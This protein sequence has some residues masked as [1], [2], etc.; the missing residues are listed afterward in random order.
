MT[1]LRGGRVNLRKF[2]HG[3]SQGCSPTASPT[4]FVIVLVLPQHFRLGDPHFHQRST[5]LKLCLTTLVY[6]GAAELAVTG[7]RSTTRDTLATRKAVAGLLMKHENMLAKVANSDEEKRILHIR[8]N[9]ANVVS[10]TLRSEDEIDNGKVEFGN[11]AS[12]LHPRL[13]PDSVTRLIF[14]KKYR[15]QTRGGRRA[16]AMGLMLRY[17][18]LRLLLNLNKTTTLIRSACQMAGAGHRL[19]HAP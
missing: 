14:Q 18:R 6:G 10:L 9:Q 1:R 4:S 2:G 5:R 19:T 13:G 15:I 11:H 8:S 3:R 16:H 7:S 17:L 12:L